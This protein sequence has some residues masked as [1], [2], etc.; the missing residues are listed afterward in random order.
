MGAMSRD[1]N[2]SDDG[3]G[4]RRHDASALR[5]VDR[6][7]AHENAHAREPRPNVGGHRRCAVLSRS[8]RWTAGLALGGHGRW[9]GDGLRWTLIWQRDLCTTAARKGHHRGCRPS[10]RW[11]SF[12]GRTSLQRKKSFAN[13]AC[14]RRSEKQQKRQKQA[15]RL[16][17]QQMRLAEARDANIHRNRRRQELRRKQV[18]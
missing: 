8:V 1:V 18:G 9:A 10:R 3:R 15:D 6:R 12:G 4:V 2:R 11:G 13:S 7:D 17:G 5:S 14:G 16:I